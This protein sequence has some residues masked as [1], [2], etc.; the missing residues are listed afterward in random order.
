MGIMVSINTLGYSVGSPLMNLVYDI[1]GTYSDGL[2]FMSCFMVVVAVAMQ[3]V[4]TAAHKERVRVEAEL[5][6]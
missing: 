5:I 4:I 2:I 1:T 6:L 3:F